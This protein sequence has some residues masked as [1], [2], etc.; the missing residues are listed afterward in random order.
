MVGCRDSF[1]LSPVGGFLIPRITRNHPLRVESMEV[2]FLSFI[3]WHQPPFRTLPLYFRRHRLLSRGLTP[4]ITR[5]DERLNCGRLAHESYAIRGR[6]HAVVGRRGSGMFKPYLPFA[7]LKNQIT[8][9][10]ERELQPF[11]F[12]MGSFGSDNALS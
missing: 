1:H 8:C 12:R 9:T 11:S 6:V 2:A 4:G 10:I 7:R 5:R 3:L